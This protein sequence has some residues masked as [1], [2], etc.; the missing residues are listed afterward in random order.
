MLS[1]ATGPDSGLYTSQAQ[2]G[3]DNNGYGLIR[4]GNKDLD[5]DNDGMPDYWEKANGSDVNV[6][7][8]MQIASDGL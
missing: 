8:A 7:D 1:E 6:N 4:S 3:L 5:T 2:T